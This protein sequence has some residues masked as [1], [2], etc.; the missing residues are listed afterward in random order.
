MLGALIAALAI[1][2][3][4]AASSKYVLIAEPPGVHTGDTIYLSG[5]GFPPN[6]PLTI[7]AVCDNILEQNNPNTHISVGTAGPTTDALGQLVAVPFRLPAL[8]DTADLYCR[9]YPSFAE[10]GNAPVVPAQQVV[11]RSTHT[12]PPNVPFVSFE[13]KKAGK[14]WLLHIRTWPGARLHLGVHYFPSYKIQRV[15]RTVGW[16]GTMTLTIPNGAYQGKGTHQATWVVG[17]S[18][19]Q[20]LKGTVDF[21][22]RLKQKPGTGYSGRCI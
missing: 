17:S 21:C 4:A 10:Q 8:P 22:E 13:P 11:F 14:T 2:G 16:Q 1:C 19:F 6:T 5:G 15:N 3:Q 12:F 7:I 20:G 18:T 9:Y